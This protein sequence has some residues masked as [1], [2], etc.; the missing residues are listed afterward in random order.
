[1]NEFE[2][3]PSFMENV[4]SKYYVH[5]YGKWVSGDYIK[6]LAF[7]MQ[8]Q[9]H[10]T[11]ALPRGHNKTT[12]L[13][14][15]LT[16]MAYKLQLND[17]IFVS[18]NVNHLDPLGDLSANRTD[19]NLPD[20]E[21]IHAIEVKS[22]ST[23]EPIEEYIKQLQDIFKFFGFKFGVGSIVDC[24]A[25]F[26]DANNQRDSMI[27]EF[28]LKNKKYDLVLI[29]DSGDIPPFFFQSCKKVLALGTPKKKS[30]LFDRAN[31]KMITPNN[32]GAALFPESF[33]V[34][35]LGNTKA[36][37]GNDS[38]TKEFGLNVEDRKDSNRDLE[39]IV[40]KIISKYLL[41]NGFRPSEI[42]G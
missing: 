12:L 13:M 42:E 36:I 16:W 5:R 18:F 4:F 33:N 14:G 10:L 40:R 30:D 9:D 17:K 31:I 24:W 38:F 19:R 27:I 37:L 1:M 34:D 41:E 23:P 21:V 2:S 6:G 11:V 15:Y 25:I 20:S 8:H 39:P 7:L 29:D 35:Y 22:D 28:G 32:E 3:F 26:V